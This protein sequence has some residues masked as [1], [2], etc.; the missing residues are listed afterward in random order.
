VA[1]LLADAAL[2]VGVIPGLFLVPL[3][4]QHADA[5]GV[6]LGTVLRAA[7]QSCTAMLNVLDA[8]QKTL[9]FRRALLDAAESHERAIAHMPGATLAVLA[10]AGADD[11]E[12]D[13]R[14]EALARGLALG[15]QLRVTTRDPAG[16][17]YCL[18]LD[19]GGW[20][21]TPILSGRTI[22][23]GTWGNLP[24]GEV[25]ITPVSGDGELLVN[26]S[27]DSLLLDEPLVVSFR[28]G[29]MQAFAP[30]DTPAGR[31]LTQL[32]TWCEQNSR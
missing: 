25:Y 16:R 5:A 9:A 19:L 1:L 6:R 18:D 32:A 17:E 24:G 20:A 2:D 30:K 31:F 11:G 3:R 26:G 10:A 12:I 29:R 23:R 27:V 13:R 7:I 28:N 15:R 21:R 8:G 14:N 4:Q 22:S